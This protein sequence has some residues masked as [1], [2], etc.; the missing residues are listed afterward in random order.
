MAHLRSFIHSLLV[1]PTLVLAVTYDF[2]DVPGFKSIPPCAQNAVTY[3]V[4]A[5]LYDN[6]QK[7]DPS[8]AYFSCLCTSDSSAVKSHITSALYGA[9]DIYTL[10]GTPEAASATSVWGNLCARNAKAAETSG[11][12][13]AQAQ[14]IPEPQLRFLRRHL[15]GVMVPTIITDY[16]KGRKLP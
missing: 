7:N 4:E 10:C 14:P 1:I 8:T 13:S 2:T 5:P 15:E 12:T 3:G 16:Q 6:C 9:T 11:A